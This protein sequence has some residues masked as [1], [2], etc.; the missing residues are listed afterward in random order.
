MKAAKSI[1]IYSIILSG[2]VLFLPSCILP[3]NY[4]AE[5]LYPAQ[6]SIPSDIQNIGV[7]NR[8]DLGP[9][10]AGYFSGDEWEAN[11]KSDSTIYKQAV[12]GMEDGLIES[13]RFNVVETLNKRNMPGFQA[14]PSKILDWK[15][16]KGI[17]PDSTDLLIE[18]AIA[19]FD[20]TILNLSPK[21]DAVEN[22]YCILSTIF[23][24][25]YNINS[26]ETSLYR[27]Q[28]TVILEYR[29]SGNH[30]RMQDLKHL[31][32]IIRSSAYKAG[33]SFATA[34]AP[35]WKE[36][37]RIYYK[38]SYPSHNSPEKLVAE[39]NWE[40]AA[41][42]WLP[43]TN[44]KN[45]FIASRACYNMALASEMCDR[46]ELAVEWV[47]KAKEL[48]LKR[49]VDEYLI[50]LYERISQKKKVDIQFGVI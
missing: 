2:L 45:K 18:L 40:G 44:F 7:F 13:P 26:E 49:Y 33:T 25:S 10:P 27:I 9:N 41:E 34:I 17:C 37:D 12:I 19:S 39:G 20:D 5:I 30:A 3:Y 22:Y 14:D 36:I 50:E 46:F 42:Q 38:S 15:Y 28:D 1:C 21:D 43:Y 16:L 4:S 29:N 6:I 32:R 48:G 8:I 47:I 24:R 23:W 35:S 11:F 31:F